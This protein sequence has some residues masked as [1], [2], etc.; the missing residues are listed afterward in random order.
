MKNTVRV[1]RNGGT[2]TACLQPEISRAKKP[3]KTP[4]TASNSG[5][6]LLIP[7]EVASAAETALKDM[8]SVGSAA[9][10]LAMMNA[11]EMNTCVSVFGG[12]ET[13]AIPG[14]GPGALELARLVCFDFN[15]ECAD[16]TGG[17]RAMMGQ[18]ENCHHPVKP[19][20]TVGSTLVDSF[21][22]ENWNLNREF[23]DAVFSLCYLLDSQGSLLSD[24]SINQIAHYTSFAIGEKLRAAFEAVSAAQVA[25]H[26]AFLAISPK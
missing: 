20:R 12:W 9:M 8:E 23:N 5:E 7:S 11:E 15:S 19:G 17:M 3:V 22:P 25:V 16:L 2:E 10:T 24:K 18:I 26:Q 14:F 1:H 13:L 6:G 21:Y 4:P